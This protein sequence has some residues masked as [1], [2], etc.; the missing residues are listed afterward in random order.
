MSEIGD[1]SRQ[2]LIDAAEELFVEKGY[3]NTTV[4]E[5]GERAGI[6]HGSIPW[7]FGN[8]PGLL[9]AV[10]VRLF[11]QSSSTE[12]FA[13]GQAG[14]NRIWQ[15]QTYFDNSPKFA[16]FG[17]F[18][19]SELEHSPAHRAEMTE[20]HIFRRNLILD[21]IHRSVA[22]DSLTLSAAPD[23]LAEFWIG[24]SRGLMAQK[25][26]LTDGFDLQCARRGLGHALDALLGATYFEHLDKS[27]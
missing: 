9:M 7:H 18:F 27:L 20:R 22:A 5:I 11:D 8:K 14:F 24:A 19:W 3:D 23:D 21:W 17:S 16:L 6:S 12:P 15:E 4:V 26:G 25:V 13:A 1:E 10:V 2:R